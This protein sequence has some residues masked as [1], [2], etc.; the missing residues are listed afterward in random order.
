MIR[1]PGRNDE[2]C[3]G[4]LASFFAT[5]TTVLSAPAEYVVSGLVIEE[6]DAVAIGHNRFVVLSTGKTLK[7]TFACTS[8]YANGSIMGYH[9]HEDSY[10]VHAAFGS[11]QPPRIPVNA[12]LPLR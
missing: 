1:E 11:D 9:T 7:N 2:D 4:D 5:F 12:L 10:A 8:S 6:E 3:R